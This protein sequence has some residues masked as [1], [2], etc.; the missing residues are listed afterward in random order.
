MQQDNGCKRE[1]AVGYCLTH[2]YYL[3]WHFIEI[4][5]HGKCIECV[6]F[7]KIHNKKGENI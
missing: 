6:K 3:D 7:I 1:D 4:V 5:K 2:N